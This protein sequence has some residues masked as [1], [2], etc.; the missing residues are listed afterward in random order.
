[1]AYE[2][3]VVDDFLQNANAKAKAIGSCGKMALK[4]CN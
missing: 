2:N 4:D 3:A 1:M